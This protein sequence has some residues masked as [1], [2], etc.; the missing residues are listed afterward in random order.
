MNVIDLSRTIAG[1]YCGQ[2]LALAG[3]DVTQVTVAGQG[4]DD[5]IDPVVWA[6][7]SRGKRTL[8]L[9]DEVRDTRLPGLLADAEALVE[10]W[11]PGALE[12]IGLDEATLRARNERLI[13]T[14]VSEFG[15]AGPWSGWAGSE[16]INLAAGGLLFLTGPWDR[17]PVQL[18]PYQAQLTSGLL[19]AVATLA[20]LYGGGPATIDCSKQESVLALIT[21]AISE[22]VYSGTVPAREGTVASMPRIERSRDGWVYAGPGAAATADYQKFAAFLEIPQLAE[23]RFATP[24]GRMANWDEHQALV[25]PRLAERTTEEWLERAAEWR[26]TFGPVQTTQEL[27]ASDVLDERG[28]FGAIETAMGSGRVPVAP[29][30]V[31]GE[32]VTAPSPGPSPAGAGEGCAG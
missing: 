17:P 28:F 21:P 23:E 10:D 25:L 18:A 20:A 12:A 26:L 31:D 32:R 15:Q 30:L 19:A 3:A 11:G 27:L 9:S 13:V 7:V 14:R 29:Y 4:P 22:Y 5:A 16:L 6:C 8:I 2:M 24:E 1:A